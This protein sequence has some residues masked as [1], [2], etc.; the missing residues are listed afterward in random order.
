[1]IFSHFK[2]ETKQFTV[3]VKHSGTP[4]FVD[5]EGREVRLYLSVDR[6]GSSAAVDLHTGYI[7]RM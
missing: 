2:V 4:V 6:G 3:R 5:L 1:M 7:W